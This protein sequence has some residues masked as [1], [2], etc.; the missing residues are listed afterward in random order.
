[1]SLL[2]KN[3]SIFIAG[4]N[5]L[6][7]NSIKKILEEENRLKKNNWKFI[8]C[9]RKELDLTKQ[10]DVFDWMRLKSPKVVII[11]AAKVGGINANNKNNSGFLLENLQ[12]QNNLIQASFELGVKR[13]LFLGS[14]CIYPKYAPQPFTEN[15]LLSGYLEQTNEGYALA[16]ICG[17][18]LCQALRNDKNF[19]TISLMPTNLYGPNDNFSKENSHVIPGLIR[20]FHEAK[21]NNSKTVECWGTGSPKREFMYVDDLAK[22]CLYLL[23]NWQPN[24][25]KSKNELNYINVGTGSEISIYDLA[26]LIKK[27]VGYQGEVLWNKKMP[28]GIPK[29]LLDIT[30][31]KNLGWKHTTN[32]KNG[33]QKTYT[34]FLDAYNSNSIRGKLK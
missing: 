31:L 19:D 34:A 3:D 8:Y 6:V 12:I 16:K 28:D 14:S 5:G 24:S 10:N 25:N 18:K 33:L 13:L 26:Y 11:A 17:I 1:M 23:E 32:L 27:I 15:S 30:K 22:C 2:T 21:I 29:K 4:H 7:G 20:K 9:R